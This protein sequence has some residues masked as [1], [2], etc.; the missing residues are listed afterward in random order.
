MK[1]HERT[2]FNNPERRACQTCGNNY[3]TVIDHGYDPESGEEYDI[4]KFCQAIPD[5][6]II[7]DDG[8]QYNCRYWKAK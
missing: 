4:C 5:R 3:S 7:N 1:K 8:V 2:C 6:D